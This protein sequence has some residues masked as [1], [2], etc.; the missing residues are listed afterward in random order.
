MAISNFRTDRNAGHLLYRYSF[1]PLGRDDEHASA[2]S[3]DVIPKA[4]L[5]VQVQAGSEGLEPLFTSAPAQQRVQ[6][7]GYGV[8]TPTL[9]LGGRLL[10]WKM[11]E[12]RTYPFSSYTTTFTIIGMAPALQFYISPTVRLT[13]S[14]GFGTFATGTSDDFGSRSSKSYPWLQFSHAL[15]AVLNRGI[16]YSHVLEYTRYNGDGDVASQI[17]FSNRLELAL[18]RDLAL[19]VNVDV[20]NTTFG[21][22]EDAYRLL[23]IGPDF[24]WFV[25]PKAALRAAVLLH[26]FIG[27]VNGL[28]NTNAWNYWSYA[29]ARVGA[30]VRF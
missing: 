30:E 22:L 2:A 13:E 29:T 28:A 19:G 18:S 1:V 20:H 9:G 11:W 8:L 3:I 16:S 17:D 25:A 10:Y 5:S 4:E 7:A 23:V 14:L 6:F 15:S 12:D 21:E 26:N 24:T 27:T